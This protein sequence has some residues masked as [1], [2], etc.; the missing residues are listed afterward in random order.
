M[1]ALEARLTGDR[2]ERCAVELRVGD[3]RE[4]VRGARPERRQTHARV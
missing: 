3:A 1:H 4:Q 2:D